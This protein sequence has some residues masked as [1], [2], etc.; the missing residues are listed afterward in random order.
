[1]SFPCVIRTY[2][3]CKGYGLAS[4]M[5]TFFG[6]GGGAGQ[7]GGG[8]AVSCVDQSNCYCIIVDFY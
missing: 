1:M 5:Y 7:G 4:V 3:I 6:G 8:G 2:P